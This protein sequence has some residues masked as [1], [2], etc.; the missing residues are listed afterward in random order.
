MKKIITRVI[1]CCITIAAIV[2]TVNKITDLFEDKQTGTYYQF[3]GYYNQK[4]DTVDVLFVGSSRVHTNINPATLWE[5]YGI[6]SYALGINSQP[7]NISYYVLKEALKT[8]HPKLVVVE[9]SQ[10]NDN[11][12]KTESTPSVSGMK[13]DIN[14][15]KAVLERRTFDSSMDTALRYPMWHTRY[16]MISKDDF[17]EDAFACYP[18]SGKAGYKGAVEHYHIVAQEYTDGYKEEGAVFSQSAEGDFDRIVKLC[19]DEGIDLL[20][21]LTPAASRFENIGVR[22]YALRKG[23][24]YL[25]TSDY[26]DEIG[27]DVATDFIDEGH[28]NVYGSTKTSSFIGRYIKDHYFIDDHRGDGRYISWD[29]NVAYHY[30]KLM[31]EAL[32]TITGFGTYLYMFPN[33][34]YIVIVSLLDG[35][36]S[37][38]IGQVDALPHV[39]CNEVIYELGGIWIEDGRSLL[40]GSFGYYDDTNPYESEGGISIGQNRATLPGEAYMVPADWNFEVGNRTFEIKRDETGRYIKID[41]IDYAVKGSDGKTAINSGI[42]LVVYDKLSEKVVDAVCFDASN[43]WAATRNK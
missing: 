27:L 11:Y 2:L 26:Y 23:V 9:A 24:S 16:D 31:N 30:H 8:Q 10:I 14:Y 15:L 28:L 36:D 21:I 7:I 39:L 42:E 12:D 19:A 1:I 35:Y 29:E 33:D 17:V 34:N 22:D 25:N 37:E 5:E 3:D 6:A 18:L 13:H 40:Y 41:G 20:F 32:P 38:Y 43:G 4:P